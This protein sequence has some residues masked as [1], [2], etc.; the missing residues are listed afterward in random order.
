MS[1]AEKKGVKKK[2]GKFSKRS[3][4]SVDGEWL[5]KAV[6]RSYRTRVVLWGCS[7]AS[8]FCSGKRDKGAYVGNIEEAYGGTCWPRKTV[9]SLDNASAGLE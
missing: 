5:T 1:K 3:Q 7:L 9:H 4:E 6:G 2:I 8:G